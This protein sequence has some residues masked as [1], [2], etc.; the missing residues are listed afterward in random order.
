V[1]AEIDR[2]NDRLKQWANHD[3]HP[4]FVSTDDDSVVG[5]YRAIMRW[6]A[7]HPRFTNAAK[8]EFADA[9]KADAWL[10]AYARATNC[11]VVTHEVYDEDIRKQI[12]IPN[13]CAAFGVK[14]V[15]TFEMLR[16]LGVRL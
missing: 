12:K 14:Y 9:G 8:N 5:H 1:K 15:N 13:V 10:V 11:T 3:F 4:W 16:A 6:A 7:T 2:G